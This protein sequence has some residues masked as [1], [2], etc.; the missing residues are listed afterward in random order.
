VSI[1]GI[2]RVSRSASASQP[3]GIA[4]TICDSSIRLLVMATHAY[5]RWRRLLLGS[6]T[7][8][9]LRETTVP[10]VLVRPQALQVFPPR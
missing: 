3:G 2:F 9:V 10:L 8:Q 5:A 7:D 6:V 1:G 4:E